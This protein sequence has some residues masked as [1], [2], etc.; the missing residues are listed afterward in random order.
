ML[1]PFPILKSEKQI[2]LESQG[3][4]FREQELLDNHELNPEKECYCGRPLRFKLERM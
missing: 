1:Y 4:L 2:Q 3:C